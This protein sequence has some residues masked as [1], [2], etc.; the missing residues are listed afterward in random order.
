MMLFES[1]SLLYFSHIITCVAVRLVAVSVEPR[2][3]MQ[4]PSF[5]KET[6]FYG[7]CKRTLRN[8]RAK[9]GIIVHRDAK[10]R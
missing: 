3:S 5:L 2:P 10:K 1:V 7:Q 8:Q 4:G 6:R 9:N